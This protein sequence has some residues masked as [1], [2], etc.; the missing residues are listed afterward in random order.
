M[1]ARRLI[2]TATVV[3]ALPLG[4]PAALA[5]GTAANPASARYTQNDV[6]RFPSG[7]E[8]SIPAVDFYETRA[9]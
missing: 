1:K 2:A 7:N 3:V 9:S 4:V 8:V 6:P 5:E